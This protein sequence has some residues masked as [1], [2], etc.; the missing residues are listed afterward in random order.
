MELLKFVAAH[1][2]MAEWLKAPVSKAGE[3]RTS[4]GS[5]PSLSARSEIAVTDGV[6]G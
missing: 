4:G 6:T 1:G 2:E 3:G 5:N